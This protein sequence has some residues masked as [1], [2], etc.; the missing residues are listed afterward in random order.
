MADCDWLIDHAD[1]PYHLGELEEA[2]H[3]S[4]L[5]S[6]RCSDQVTLWLQVHD[7]RI[8]QAWQ[9][10][11]G[12]LVS[13]AGASFLCEWCETKSIDEITQT[14]PEDYLQQLGT[15]TPMRQQC[16]LLAFH[17]LHQALSN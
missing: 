17:C 11:S 15:L 2:T 12:C 9:Q 16:A 8:S 7:G 3:Q 13:T 5:A 4:S 10:S 14:A 1:S 6:N